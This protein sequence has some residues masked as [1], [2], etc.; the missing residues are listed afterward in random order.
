MAIACWIVTRRLS[1]VGWT[2]G[3]PEASRTAMGFSRAPRAGTCGMSSKAIYDFFLT[4]RRLFLAVLAIEIATNFTG[5][6]EAYLILMMTA[7]HNSFFAAY[8]V[9]SASRAAQFAFLFCSARTRHSG[10]GG[11]RDVAGSRICGERGRFLGHHSQDSHGLL[12][13]GWPASGVEVRDRIAGR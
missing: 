6:V 5:V 13:N 2:L 10:R 12:G 8:L 4:R 1:L 11:R 7:A 3:L 9:E